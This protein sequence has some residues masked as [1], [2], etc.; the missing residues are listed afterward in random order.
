MATTHDP[1]A[2]STGQSS[3][4]TLGSVKEKLTDAAS[5]VRDTA[6]QYGNAAADNIDR[7]VRSA[8]GA[9]ESTASTL[10]SQAGNAPGKVSDM[11]QTAATKLDSTAQYLREFD[12]R[13]VLTH[14]E[15]WTR[16]NPGIAIFS[17]AA[18][19]FLIGMSLKRDSSDY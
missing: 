17:A 9:L 14:L 5:Q 15:D 7:N 12:T 2:P 19:G 10:R 11:A 6:S 18:V 16:R 13:E 3:G 1:L 8:A 4:S